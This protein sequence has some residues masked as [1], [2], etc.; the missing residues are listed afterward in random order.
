MRATPPSGPQLKAFLSGKKQLPPPFKKRRAQRKKQ[1][2]SQQAIRKRIVQWAM[3][4]CK[5]SAQ[6]AYSQNGN[7]RLSQLGKGASVPLATDCSGFATLC[8][9]WAGAPNP[10]AAGAFDARQPAFTGSMLGHCRKIPRSAVQPGDLVV[11]TPPGTGQH[12]CAGG[13]RRRRPDARLARRRLRPEEAPLLGRGR[14]PAHPRARHGRLAQRVL[15]ETAHERCRHP[16]PARP[17]RRPDALRSSRRSRTRTRR[18]SSPP[19]S[20]S[21]AAGSPAATSTSSSK[22]R[23]RSSSKANRAPS[24]RAA[25]SSARSRR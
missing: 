11:W 1:A 23:R 9:S 18:T 2:G 19:V 5:N 10:N 24:S 13:R 16:G 12:V 22:V 4:G 21:C 7:V 6:I 17:V 8:Y 20:G 3:W 25:T 14:L 15:V